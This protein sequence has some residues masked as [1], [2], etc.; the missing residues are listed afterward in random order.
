MFCDY[1]PDMQSVDPNTWSMFTNKDPCIWVVYPAGAAGDLLVSIIDK[2]YLR[3]GCEYYGIDEYGR[4]MI[5]SS[6]YKMINIASNA[7]TEIQFDDQWFYD[8]SSQLGDRNL[9]YSMLDQVIFS[10]HLHRPHEIKKI[11]N[12]F[13]QAKIINIFAK[14]GF[15]N[16]VIKLLIKYKHDH[17]IPE[18]LSFQHI[19]TT[20]YAPN[21]VDHDRLLNIPFGCLFDRQSYD[22]YYTII[23]DFLGLPAPLISFDFVKF[24]LSK[25]HPVGRSLLKHCSQNL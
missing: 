2:H 9:T 10:C 5:H 17:V 4:V 16:S 14:D 1:R 15:A 11:L 23:R 6:D 12:N 18:T 21:L 19:E 25:Q 8:F 7:R 13:Q 3:T 24:Y 20:S 22:K